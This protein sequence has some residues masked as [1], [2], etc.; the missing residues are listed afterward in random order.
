MIASNIYPRPH[1]FDRVGNQVAADQRRLH[2]FRTH[3]DAIGD[4]DGVELH[5][6]AAGSAHAFLDP[7][8][9]RAQVDVAR[10]GLDPGIGNANDRLR[11]VFIG[12]TNRLEH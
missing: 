6:R 2:A 10:H 11:Q 8:R 12:E 4:S 1:Q 7:R 9:Q 3:G 5:R